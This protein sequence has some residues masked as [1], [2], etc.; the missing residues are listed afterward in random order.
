MA[1]GRLAATGSVW[2]LFFFAALVER[3]P[4][5]SG[6]QAA[7]EPLELKTLDRNIPD[8]GGEVILVLAS[9]VV[10]FR[11]RNFTPVD[12]PSEGQEVLV[13]SLQSQAQ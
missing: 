11:N 8:W 1:T 9:H 10:S 4:S 13:L 5:F 3:Y 2:L 6:P 7:F 12:E